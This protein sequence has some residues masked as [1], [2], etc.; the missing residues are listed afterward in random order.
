M[1]AKLIIGFLL[2]FMSDSIISQESPKTNTALN[3]VK[4]NAPFLIFGFAEITY[5]RVRNKGSSYGASIYY[6]IEDNIDFKFGLIPYYRVY[7]GRGKAKGIFWEGNGSFF[8]TEERA[9]KNTPGLGLG[10]SVGWKLL[11]K[12]GWIGEIYSGGGINFV[13][14]STAPGSYPRVGASIGKRF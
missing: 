9:N 2:L 4:F 3:E 11:T 14:N 13:R 6:S 1:K 12:R 5:E 10:F 8:L 7:I